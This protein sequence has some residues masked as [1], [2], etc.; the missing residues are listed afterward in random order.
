[1]IILLIGFVGTFALNFNVWVPVLAKQALGQGATEFGFLM[2]A[3]GVGAL[4][5]ALSLAFLSHRGP[6]LNLIIIGALLLSSFEIAMWWVQWYPLAIATLFAIGWSMI[7]CTATS[8]S[9]IQV[10]VPDHLRGR[11]MSVYFL[12]FGGT[13]PIG[14]LFAGTVS[15]L[16]GANAGFATGGA[17]SLIGTLLLLLWWRRSAAEPDAAGG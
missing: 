17:V 9:T 4:T 11:V 16:W 2:S 13:T 8:N 1:M 15:D 6:Q 7:T 3:V 5:G 10:T 14:G 12:V